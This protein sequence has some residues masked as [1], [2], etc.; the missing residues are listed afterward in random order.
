[1]FD[2]VTYILAKKA[3]GGGSGSDSGYKG[4]VAT[5]SALPA[6]ASQGDS[7]FVTDEGCTY[8]YDGGWKQ[9]PTAITEAQ[10]RALF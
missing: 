3:G 8:I 5:A 10:I 4:T 1:M 9:S 6:S 7:Y 2:P